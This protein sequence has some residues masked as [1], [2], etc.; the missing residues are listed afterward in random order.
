MP[1]WKLVITSYHLNRTV[2]DTYSFI[3]IPIPAVNDCEGTRH[4]FDWFSGS[5]VC[6]FQLQTISPVQP[7]FNHELRLVTVLRTVGIKYFGSQASGPTGRSSVPAP[8]A[9]NS[10]LNLFIT[11]VLAFSMEISD[12]GDGVLELIGS[13]FCIPE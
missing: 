7:E 4:S 11:S 3:I 13:K 6:T 2:P 1:A 12:G 10:Y 9:C 5:H 8:S